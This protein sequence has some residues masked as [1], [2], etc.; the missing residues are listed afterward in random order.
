MLEE[1][2]IVGPTCWIKYRKWPIKPPLSKR[3]FLQLPFHLRGWEQ[4]PHRFN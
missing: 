3:P 4:K 2:F 1:I